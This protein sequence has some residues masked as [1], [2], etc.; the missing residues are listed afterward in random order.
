M[1]KRSRHYKQTTFSGQK[2]RQDKG[3]LFVIQ[4]GVNNKL[5]E[6]V[7]YCSSSVFILS[8]NQVS[9]ESSLFLH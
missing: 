5:Q 1:Y 9:H 8:L 3:I 7:Q 4:S 2:Q 6:K